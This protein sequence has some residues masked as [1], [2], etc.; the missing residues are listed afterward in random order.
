MASFLQSLFVRECRNISK[1][2]IPLGEDRRKHLIITGKN[3]SGKTSLLNEMHRFLSGLFDGE[4]SAIEQHRRELTV[5]TQLESSIADLNEWI[6][7]KFGGCDLRFS[8]EAQLQQGIQQGSFL[9]AFFNARRESRVDVPTGINKVDLQTHVAPSDRENMKFIQYIVNLKADRSFARDD[10]KMHEAVAIDEWFDRFEARLRTMFQA[11]DLK[12]EFDRR[13]YNFSIHIGGMRPFGFDTL[14]DGYSAIL[15]ITTELLLRME[16]HGRRAYDLEG[17]VLIDELETHLHVELQKLV[18]P[19]LTDFFPN[20]QFVVTTHSPFVISS[21]SNAVVCDLEKGFVTEDLSGYSYDT[22]IESYFGS[23]KYSD[24]LKKKLAEYELLVSSTE[25]T[26][27][28]TQRL[29]ELDGYFDAIPKYFANELA[30]RLQQIKL[31]RLEQ[32]AVVQ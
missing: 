17:L 2:W 19:F 24:E 12:L 16:A 18:L 28:E 6:H 21:V 13:T 26:D 1:L 9:L 25:L 23:D 32:A 20:I 27:E 7:D 15:S 3:G 22:L 11:P 29:E 14:S 4:I 10:G 8:S 31:R 5:R 30:V